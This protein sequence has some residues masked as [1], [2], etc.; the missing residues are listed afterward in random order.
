MGV[1]RVSIPVASI[2]VMHRALTDFFTDL[3]G[4]PT[5]ILA[6]EVHRL[7]SF[8]DYTNFVGLPEYRELENKYLPRRPGAS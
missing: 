8:R 4:S 2:L 6:G 7:T 1:A 5:G 3:R